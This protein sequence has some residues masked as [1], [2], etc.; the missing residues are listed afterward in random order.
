[1]TDLR[2]LAIQT[3]ILVVI[4]D[5]ALRA[6]VLA[7]LESVGT[8]IIAENTFE[9]E[10]M[11]R[12]EQFG[13]LIA[14]DEQVAETGVMFFAR[15]NNRH[16]WMRRI[17]L[18]R[19]VEPE[20][21]V[22]MINEANVFRC[23]TLPLDPVAFRRLAIGAAEDHVRLRRLAQAA[24][25]GERWRA[26]QT[27]GSARSALMPTS[28]RQWIGSLPR[29]FSMTLLASLWALLLG[30]LVLLILYLLKTALGFDFIEGIHLSDLFR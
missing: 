12:Q 4:P 5:E 17:L 21:L 13:L 18:C 3:T 15:I 9:A 1:M 2:A 22:Y 29:T 6:Q 24:A 11:L 10:G 25:D 19:R 28:V 20:L 30:V 26:E 8:T 23:A 7:A 14:Q 16:P 27:K